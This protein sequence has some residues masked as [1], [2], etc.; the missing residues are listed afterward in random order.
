[1]DGARDTT[2]PEGPWEFDA[3]VA[4]AFDDMLARSIPDYE[5]MRHTVGELA[6]RYLRDEGRYDRGPHLVD[7]GCSRGQAIRSVIGDGPIAEWSAVRATGLEVSEPM[8]EAAQAE[9]EGDP[10]V[11]IYPWDLRGEP[12][13]PTALWPT[14]VLSVLTVQFVPIEH[15][16]KIVTAVAERL[17]DGGAFLLVEKVL[18]AT[19]HID[20]LL[21]DAYYDLKRA[22]GYDQDS[23][24]RKRLSLE[25]VLVPITAAWNED[26]LRQAGFRTVE[27]VWRRLNFAA[28]LAIR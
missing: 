1:M 19:H 28:W 16:L 8:V 22:H 11:D 26:L 4:G 2:Q 20:E 18:G 27:C 21:V 24:D 10:R 7:L 23:I 17:P 15:R 12:T 9:F 14:V 25:G 13:L 3:E 5:G 6:R